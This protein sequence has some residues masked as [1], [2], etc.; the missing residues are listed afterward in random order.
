MNGKYSFVSMLG[1]LMLGVFSSATIQAHGA[2]ASPVSRAL[3]CYTDGGFYWPTDGSGVPNAACRQAFL[4]SGTLPFTDWPANSVNVADFNN[5]A[6]VRAA[7]P[8]GLLC[9]AGQM[10]RAGQDAVSP[11]WHRTPIAPENGQIQLDYNLTKDHVPSFFEFYLSKPGY[12]GDRP[13][14][15][16]D[17]ELVQTISD[18]TGYYLPNGGYRLPVAIP[19]G[20][21]GDAVIYT[22][23]QRMDGAGEGFYA[24]SDVR[25]TGG[26]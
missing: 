1:V 23:W 9:S 20:R 16:D 12:S 19:Q 6:A 5:P 14:A 13:L 7:I 11:D 25:I 24:C 8:D 21:E 22:R 18:P 15:W 26:R 4:Q 10:G 3:K 17:L 2:P